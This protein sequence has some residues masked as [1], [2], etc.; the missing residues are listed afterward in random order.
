MKIITYHD[1]VRKQHW[2]DSLSKC[3]WSAGIFLR[4][5]LADDS[6]FDTLG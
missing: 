5:M 1:S 3:D 6:I 4:K 2:L